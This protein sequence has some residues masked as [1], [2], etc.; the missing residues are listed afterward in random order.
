MSRI[1]ILLGAWTLCCSSLSFADGVRLD[2]RSVADSCRFVY[3]IETDFE[4]AADGTDQVVVWLKDLYTD[5]FL[6]PETFAV[7]DGKA[8]FTSVTMSQNPKYLAHE[9]YFASYASGDAVPEK[10]TAKADFSWLMRR[11]YELTERDYVFFQPLAIEAL[12]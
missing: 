5:A 7:E 3:R 6:A 4:L 12:P 2:A 11:C 9:L 1:K 8:S 10:P